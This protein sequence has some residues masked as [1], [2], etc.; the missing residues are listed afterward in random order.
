LATSTTTST[1]S[2]S[3]TSGGA[4]P[5]FPFQILAV[6]ALTGLIAASYLYVRRRNLAK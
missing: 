1:T 5:E 4:V 6:V 2:A 3:T